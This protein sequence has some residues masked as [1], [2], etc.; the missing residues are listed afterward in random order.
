[1][2][3]LIAEKKYELIRTVVE[4][5]GQKQYIYR[6]M[7][8]DGI[9]FEEMNFDLPLDKFDSW[10]D[11]VKERDKQ[12]VRRLER[13]RTAISKG[14]YRLLD[15]K[16]LQTHIC[17]DKG[18]QKDIQALRIELPDGSVIAYVQPYP[19]QKSPKGVYKMS[20]ADHLTEIKR[21]NRKL[22]DLRVV[23]NY[24][25][26]ITFDDGSKT[27][28]SYGGNQSLEQKMAGTEKG[29]TNQSD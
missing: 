26:E 24:T 18:D 16:T 19:Y 21:G 20:W 2:K 3:K 25:Y 17:R 4:K 14:R 22:I 7:L 12:R 11:Y 29:R 6:F 28:F 8:P 5:D 10:E 15:I 1:M 13:I 23:R 27:I 9:K